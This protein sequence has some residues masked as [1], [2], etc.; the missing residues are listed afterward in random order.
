M[1][2]DGGVFQPIYEADK[3]RMYIQQ[4]VNGFTRQPWLNEPTTCFN[5]SMY[6]FFYYYYYAHRAHFMYYHAST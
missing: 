5:F 1:P 2:S 6:F 4:V 3:I